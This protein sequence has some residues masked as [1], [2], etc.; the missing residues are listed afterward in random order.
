M[1]M[2]A[3]AKCWTADEVRALIEANP[4][5]TPRYE[6]IDGELLV[7]SAPNY[8]HQRA[9]S[10]LW[11]LL[12][13][14]LRVHGVGEAAVSPFEVEL[15]PESLAQPDVFVIPPLPKPRPR[16]LRQVKRLLLAAEVI[17]PSSARYDRVKKRGTTCATA[18]PNTGSWISR[19][20]SSSD[21]SRATSGP[22]Y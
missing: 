10:R 16:R 3:T 15:E 6:L 20:A 5:Q 19:R 22:K 4:L 17:S 2:P 7:T 1:V 18:L 13:D 12:D 14:Y 21:R 8:D 9:V 11:R